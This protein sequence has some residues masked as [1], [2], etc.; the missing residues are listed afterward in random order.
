MIIDNLHNNTIYRPINKRLNKAF[1]YLINTDFNTIQPGKYEIDGDEIFAMV[2]EYQPKPIKE[3][4]WEA[5]E[6]YIDIQYMAKG[7]EKVGYCNIDELIVEK[8]YDPDSDVI[9]GQA[10]GDIIT[11][12]E[13]NFMIFFPQDLHKPGIEYNNDREMV[14]KVVVKVKI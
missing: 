11:L 6:K 5:H 4:M 10:E 13:G 9:L 8:E 3:G 12:N 1:D 7:I 2:F 14:K